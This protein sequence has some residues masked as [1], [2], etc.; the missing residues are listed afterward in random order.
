MCFSMMRTFE[1]PCSELNF[2]DRRARSPRYFYFGKSTSRAIYKSAF[3]DSE[4]VI[5]FVER[6]K[7]RAHTEVTG[8]ERQEGTIT[9]SVSAYPEECG[10]ALL[11]AFFL[12]HKERAYRLVR[13]ANDSWRLNRAALPIECSPR[14]AA[15][16]RQLFVPHKTIS[17]KPPTRTNVAS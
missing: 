4:S 12:R 3:T 10:A 5:I 2:F 1:I 15:R 8:A 6:K 11:P 14:W 17:R 16:L 9:N 7:R 13:Y